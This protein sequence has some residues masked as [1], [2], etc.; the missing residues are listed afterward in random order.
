VHRVRFEH[1]LNI[2]D[3][4]YDAAS[5]VRCAEFLPGDLAG[6]GLRINTEQLGGFVGGYGKGLDNGHG[7]DLN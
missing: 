5:D 7:Y 3:P 4:D 2:G 6:D 1:F